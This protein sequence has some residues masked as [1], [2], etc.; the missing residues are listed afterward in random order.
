MNKKPYKMLFDIN[1]AL[2][3]NSLSNKKLSEKLSDKKLKKLITQFQDF[4]E[5]HIY[6]LSKKDIL[7]IAFMWNS[8]VSHRRRKMDILTILKVFYNS[9]SERIFNFPIIIKLLKKDVFFTVKKR[10]P[11][12]QQDSNHSNPNIIYSKHELLNSHIQLSNNL[13]RQIL[14]ENEEISTLNNKSYSTNKDFIDDWFSYLNKLDKFSRRNFQST[15][16]VTKYDDIVAINY[17]EIV[18]WKA[19]IERRLERTEIVLPLKD[20]VDEYLLDEKEETIIIYLM[21]YELEGGR[22]SSESVIQLISSDIHEM[23]NNKRYISID[24][25]LVKNGLIEISESLTFLSRGNDI[26]VSPDITRRIITKSPI[27][28]EEKIM[29]I[30]KGN[31]IFTLVE[32]TQT[33]EELILP[34]EM[35]K[36]ITFSLN[37]YSKNIDRT[38]RK[39]KLYD[40]GIYSVENSNK[41]LE[42]GMLS[43]FYGLPGTGKTF[44]AGAVAQ[45]MGKKLL[46]TDVSRIQSKW[47]G[48]S[49]KNVRRMFTVFERIVR[50]VKNP[51]VLLL[52]EADQFLTKRLSNTNS[53]VDKMYN[54]LQNIFLEAFENFRGV[55]IATTNL[56]NNLDEAFSRRF[57]LKLEF[58]LPESEERVKL[59]K[60][61]LPVSIPGSQFICLNSI[62]D[63]Y[64][65]SGGQIKVIVRNAC[66]EA[67][68]REGIQKAI[69]QK[70]LVKYC[71]IESD[72]CFV[73]RRSIGF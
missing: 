10:V 69:M 42:P 33:F 58:P 39:W 64:V 32:P 52:N 2:L 55:L 50:R 18:E 30:I 21:K 14:G 73:R 38:L 8:Y 4:S 20:L 22:C 65:L 48:D 59:W 13:I 27:T 43:L 19:R 29:Q 60:L 3:S 54:S 34:T 71:E 6:N 26:R 28:D 9:Y 25:K 11:Y 66:I 61:H 44:A 31:N 23:Y 63:K 68:S 40:E 62:A 45:A 15:Q 36:T 35:K 7:L 67:A 47:V 70:D 49:E 57:H 16:R 51:P 12:G 72:S 1:S 53:S 24:S 5:F 37:Q 56:R 17:L 46:I 41:D